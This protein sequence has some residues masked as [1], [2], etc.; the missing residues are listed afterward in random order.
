MMGKHPRIGASH[1]R[2]IS[3]L[4][5]C[6]TALLAVGFPTTAWAYVG[7]GAGLTAVGTVLALLAAVGLLIAGFV[8]YPVKR[9]L[10]RRRPPNQRADDARSEAQK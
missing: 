2:S 8:W 6:G 9:L 7:P 3:G 4:I 10:R 5:A 1:T